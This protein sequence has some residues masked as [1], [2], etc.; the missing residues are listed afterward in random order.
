MPVR[1]GRPAPDF[2]AVALLPN[3]QFQTLS[4]S[5]FR[6]SYL[7]LFF[8]PLDFTFVCPTEIIEFSEKIQL[9]R[10]INCEVVACSVDSKFSHLA[11]VKTPRHKGGLE[12][13]NYPIISDLTKEISR[14]YDVLIEDGE[15]A[16]VS[17][18]GLFIIDRQGIVRHVTIND[19][20]VGRNVEEVL[21]VVKAFQFVEEHGEVCPSSWTPGAPTI[22]PHPEHSQEYFEVSFQEGDRQ[23][24]KK[25]KT[26]DS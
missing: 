8:Y 11:W 22:K 17:L 13:I 6:G 14:N 25:R 5:D 3:K 15:D 19:L 10:E 20:P 16:G 23:M 4:L 2:S 24:S 1:V 18:R 9:F 26:I 7:V 12:S 21:R